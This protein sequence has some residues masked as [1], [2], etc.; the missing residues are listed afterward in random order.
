MLV[1]LGA[2]WCGVFW[3]VLIYRIAESR[4]LLSGQLVAINR[5]VGQN[6]LL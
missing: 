4:F 2:G 3:D 6:N 5:Y 1:S